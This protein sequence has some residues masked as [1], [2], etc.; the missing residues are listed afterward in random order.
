MP[1]LSPEERLKRKNKFDGNLV[2]GVNKFNLLT[3]RD[4]H[5]DSRKKASEQ[6]D[7]IN[8]STG[9]LRQDFIREHPCP[10]CNSTGGNVLFVK[11]G[12]P[13]LRCDCGMV[14]VNPVLKEE[15]LHSAYQDEESYTRVL[16]N[17]IQMDMD[18]KKSDYALDIVENYLPQKGNLL[19][20]GCGPGTFLEVAQKRG[21]KVKGVEFN[22]WCV[23]R[24]REM[25]IEVINIPLEQ[26]NIPDNSVECVT[27][28]GVLEH[29]FDPKHF[30][31]ILHRVLVPGGII[32]F[33]LPNIESLAVRILHE[34]CVTFAGN[35]HINHFSATTLS[36]LLKQSS[37]DVKEFETLLTEIGTINNYLDFR[38]PYF[39]DGKP[40]MDILTPKYIHDNMLGYALFALA[41]KISDRP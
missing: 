24:L 34:D 40:T 23:N 6:P 17:K 7:F 22:S 11:E 2:F 5:L 41:S 16:L 20:I 28:W 1:P 9:R 21:W 33:M 4:K 31:A 3:G 26:V 32:L 18:K 35:F 30:L 13:H 29:I 27:L 14:Y 25:D 37:F 38:D 36:L 39:G 10:L 19:D 12:F 15:K 8:P